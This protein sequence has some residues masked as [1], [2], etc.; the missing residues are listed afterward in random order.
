MFQGAWCS[1]DVVGGREREGEGYL[2]VL[3]QC[4]VYGLMG[5]D[6]GGKGG[7]ERVE[8][9][10]KW[11]EHLNGVHGRGVDRCSTR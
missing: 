11:L 2:S 5:K 4:H 1:G 10:C 3:A 7:W 8:G 9:G 6:E